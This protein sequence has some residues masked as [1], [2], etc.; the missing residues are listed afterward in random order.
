MWGNVFP[1]LMEETCFR[2]VWSSMMVSAFELGKARYLET[3]PDARFPTLSWEHESFS[4][5]WNML[6]TRAFDG[7]NID[8]LVAGVSFGD[9]GLVVDHTKSPVFP[10]DSSAAFVFALTQDQLEELRNEDNAVACAMHS[11]F[12][13]AQGLC[14]GDFKEEIERL[15]TGGLT[16]AEFTDRIDPELH[17]GFGVQKEAPDIDWKLLRH[18]QSLEAE[19]RSSDCFP[20]CVQEEQKAAIPV[21]VRQR[22]PGHHSSGQVNWLRRVPAIER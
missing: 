5:R 8:I 21:Q 11:T 1:M 16:F 2:C 17:P 9:E 12:L 14:A 18:A 7:V 3:D 10:F 22:R 6:F 13:V 4:K 19:G 15:E 20:Q